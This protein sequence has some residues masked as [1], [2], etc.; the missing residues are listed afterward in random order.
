MGYS[1]I[2]FEKKDKAAYITLNTPPSNWLTIL[3]MREINE[4]LA[5]LKKDPSVQLLI[6]DHA[7]EKAF[8]DGVDVADLSL[9]HI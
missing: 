6:F 7:G 1:Y 4:V 8:C 5:E 9:I 2:T 3:M